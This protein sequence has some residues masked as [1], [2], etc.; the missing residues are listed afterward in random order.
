[1]TDNLTN[2]DGPD[3]VDESVHP[4]EAR[5]A[6]ALTGKGGASL[7][8][9][10]AFLGAFD[11]DEDIVELRALGVRANRGKDYASSSFAWD[12]EQVAELAAKAERGEFGTVW[13]RRPVT[14]LAT[15]IYMMPNGL[16][17]DLRAAR[18]PGKWE[19][20]EA[21]KDADITQRRV[22]CV[23]L[24]PRRRS[25]ISSTNEEMYA[26][27]AVACSVHERLS[28]MLGA[29]C[30]GYGHSGNGRHVLIGIANVPESV[31]MHDACVRIL[32]ALD[33][34]HS[35]DAVKVDQ[36]LAN[37]ARI[38][39][40]YGTTKRKGNSIEERPHRVS[41]FV[42]PSPEEQRRLTLEEI[43]ELRDALEA[44]AAELGPD[45]AGQAEPTDRP[46]AKRNAPSKKS[47]GKKS[48]K[49]KKSKGSSA[50][51]DIFE[52]ANDVPIRQVVDALGLAV[53]DG[54]TPHVRCPG[55]NRGPSASH[56]LL[57]RA[58]RH[59]CSTDT[60]ARTTKDG[61]R[62]CVDLWIAVHNVEPLEAARAI[63]GAF[64]IET[65]SQRH[66]RQRVSARASAI[67]SGSARVVREH[68]RKSEKGAVLKTRENLC[69]ILERH[70]ALSG[71][72]AYDERFDCVLWLRGLDGESGPGTGW[73]RE[74]RDT[75]EVEIARFIER[76]FWLEFPDTKLHAAINAVAAA[77]RFDAV[78]TYLDELVWDGVARLDS[79][80]VD[81][82]GVEDT[83]LHR[84]FG[85]KW[86][87]SAVARALQ[88]GSKVD[89]VLVL[90]GPQ[91]A[92]K[93]SGLMALCPEPRLFCDSLPDLR[94]TKAAAEVIQ[95]PWIVE[96][97][98]L[99]ALN[100]A[101][102][103]TVKRYLTQ[104]QDR[105]RAAY[106]RRSLTR[107]RRCVFAAS[108]NDASYLKD[109]TGGRRFWP[110]PVG[111]V[112]VE[113][114]RAGRDQLW[115]EAVARYQAGETW[116]LDGELE[117]SAS[118]AQEE[119]HQ[120]DTWGEVVGDYLDDL[121]P[122]A[123]RWIS[124]AQ[125]LTTALGIEP[126]H[127]TRQHQNRLGEAMRDVKGWEAHRKRNGGPKVR[128]YRRVIRLIGGANGGGPSVGPTSGPT[129]GPTVGRPGP[130]LVAGPDVGPEVGPEENSTIT[131]TYPT[132]A[133]RANLN[134]NRTPN[135]G[136]GRSCITH[137]A[138]TH[139]S[140][141]RAHARGDGPASEAL[142][143]GFLD[144][145]LEDDP[146][147][148]DRWSDDRCEAEGGEV[149][150]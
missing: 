133:N 17:P 5:I 82:F 132:R 55:C 107:P 1:M 137:D 30:L 65:P 134:T 77:N 97:A 92:R 6:E 148:P 85:S 80:L 93:S 71:A 25:G 38:L 76:E 16:T 101:E 61:R 45:D 28:A 12:A 78:A 88:P 7:R 98:E 120:G 141:S 84:A 22:L 150:S 68:L 50:G 86:M 127:Q 74:I 106:G 131:P 57:E 73:P 79:W 42:G 66:Q 102:A 90:E 114:I 96:I 138:E 145:D 136:K 110:V 63:C 135:E 121:P 15:A 24:D 128:G 125:L 119:R 117:S 44:L 21:V 41:A 3:G 9:W 18:T 105:Y 62:G 94:D 144:D 60:C 72:L 143:D 40:A 48:K 13:S 19:R 81:F 104:Q 147:D 31:E 35:T 99:D 52:L 39:P 115:A 123:D 2:G 112:D 124:T 8:R 122:K 53:E 54:D 49:S 95:G 142:P 26:S 20:G 140:P 70:D 37:A 129:P 130:A 83:P 33:V 29:E 116:W 126:K 43:F 111:D 32:A 56:V 46:S 146:D 113:G 69:V 27:A 11:G 4:L 91:G 108:T 89:H 87:I 139:V 36:V 51:P 34:L 58:N 149:G 118:E 109:S 100:K 75:D 10:L 103:S 14:E 23:D 67:E 64:N 59:K 47:K